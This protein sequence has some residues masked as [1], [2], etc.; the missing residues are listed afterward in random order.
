MENVPATTYSS[1]ASFSRLMQKFERK[2]NAKNVLNVQAFTHTSN[3]FADSHLT[4]FD[5]IS[6]NLFKM[7]TS[8]RSYRDSMEPHSQKY[9]NLLFTVSHALS[10]RTLQSFAL[11]YI[12]IRIYILRHAKNK[13]K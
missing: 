4:L 8:N 9:S 6:G 11:I 3:L 2:K 13:L 1:L 10:L 12:Y 7:T 5:C